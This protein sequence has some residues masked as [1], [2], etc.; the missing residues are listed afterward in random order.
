MT[1]HA[2]IDVKPSQVEAPLNFLAP[3]EGR[4][5]LYLCDPPEGVPVRSGVYEDHLV[6][7]T[8]ARPIAGSLSL[9]RQGFALLDKP[10][11]LDRFDDEQAIKSIY[12]P[13]VERLLRETTGAELVVTFDHNVRNAARFEKGEAGIRGPVERTHNDFTHKSGPERARKELEER[14]FDADMLLRH[15]FSMINLWR[16]VGHTVRKS[17][18]AFCSADTLGPKDLLELDLIYADRVGEIHSVLYSSGQRWFYF[19]EL[20]TD[21]AALIKC[22]DSVDDGSIAR[23]TAHSAFT[24]PTSPPDAPYARASRRARW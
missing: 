21:E 4:P 3:M 15:R 1:A 5:H 12:Y 11:A 9:D 20:Q 2:R 17:P 18:L 6:T 14:G 23:F 13:E 24:D 7:I 10:T 19:P 22:Y 16:P 8:N